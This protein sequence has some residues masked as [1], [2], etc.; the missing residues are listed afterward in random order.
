MEQDTGALPRRSA[1][2]AVRTRP[3]VPPRS[4]YQQQRLSK[5]TTQAASSTALTIP[6]PTGVL[7]ACPVQGA[8]EPVADY[9]GRLQVFTD[10]VATAKAQQEAAQADRQRLANEAAAQ[11]QQTAEA[12]A[13]AR[14]RRNAASTES[15]IQ[16]ENQWTTLLE[17]MFFVPTEA[18]AAPT[19]AE[20]ERSNLA[21][22][23]LSV[24]RGVMWN[25]K[26]LQAHLLAERQQ[27]QK[28]QQEVA[29]LTAAV[30]DAATQQQQ[31]QQLLN[32]TL[33]RINGIEAKASAAPGCTTD[34]TKQLN[35]RI[36]HVVTIIGELGDFTSSATISSTVAAIKTSI[37]KLQT[38]PDAATKNYKMP[39]FDISKFDDYNKSDALTWWQSFLTEASCRTVPADDMMKALYLQLI[40]GAQAW[41]NHLAAT[42]KCTIAELHTHITW[43]EFE[44]LWFT[45]FM[46]RNV[47]K[48]AMNEVYTCSQ[49]S[50]PTRDWTT[51]WQK[52]VTTPGFDLSFGPR[53]RRKTQPT[54]VTLA[55]GRTQKSIDQCVEGVPVYFVPLACEPV[56]FDIL[57]TK[58]DMILGMSWLRSADHPVNFHDRTVHIRD[59]NGVLVL[60][61]V[62]TPHTSIACHVVSIAR[63]RDTIARNDVEEI[64]LVFLHAL[65]SPNRPAAS[66]PDPRIT[67]LLDEY[68]DVFEAPTGTA[69][70]ETIPDQENLVNLPLEHGNIGGAYDRQGS[71]RDGDISCHERRVR[72]KGICVK[73]SSSVDGD[74]IL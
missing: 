37:T 45:R 19:Q 62:A 18:Q 8:L 39:H 27:R 29:A 42:K 12:D 40:G 57:D 66:P 21:T 34:A 30:R 74:G 28:H 41:M 23:M 64:G 49:G 68:G 50:M 9:L 32:S 38:R 72:R 48:A 22:L 47:V 3:V 70:T 10:A 71:R 69:P 43:K 36:D 73:A 31:Q 25:N 15:L 67:H 60:C 6:V 7:S 20:G 24:M 14:D 58:F 46:V 13:A 4:K 33:A 54:Q 61:T 11:A 52:I 5:R 56:S 1:R 44:Q 65:P 51:K 26:L 59:R 55:D 16:H 63:I 35:E 17:G 53:V 2:L